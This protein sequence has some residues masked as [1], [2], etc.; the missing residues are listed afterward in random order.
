MKFLKNIFIVFAAFVLAMPVY[1]LANSPVHK[2]KH[3]Y[4]KSAEKQKTTTCKE[5]AELL[6]ESEETDVET[7]YADF[8]PDNRHFSSGYQILH[9]NCLRN[10]SHAVAK[11]RPRYL[12]INRLT[13]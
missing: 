4:F 12:V 10:Y 6:E 5:D 1:S 7:I 13:L 11:S 2:N 9:K 3:T 8:F